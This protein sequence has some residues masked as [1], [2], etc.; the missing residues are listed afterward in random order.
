MGVGANIFVGLILSRYI[1]RKLGDER[2][3]IW[4]LVFSIIDYFWFLDMGLNPAVTN[5]CARYL[6]RRQNDKINEVVTTALFY[7]S[8]IAVLIMGLTVLLSNQ[9][10]RWFNV[11]PAH[12]A[13]FSTLILITGLSWSLC[14]V[15]H[16]FVSCLDGFQ[17]F[18]L[19]SP[20][21]VGTVILR[22]AASALLL[23]FG[24]GLVAMGI[25]FVC[26][27]VLGY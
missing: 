20:V 8:L 16:M 3:G 24:Y 13:E 2:Y 21:L 25:S 11:A 5:F 15:L 6:A 18:D 10:V 26:F 17:R 22:S 4:A 27:Q 14:V 19:T 1:I 9:M 7:F 23:M 12:R